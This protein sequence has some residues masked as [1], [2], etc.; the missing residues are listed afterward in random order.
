LRHYDPDLLLEKTAAARPHK[1]PQA[2]LSTTWPSTVVIMIVPAWR[3]ARWLQ[4]H[5]GQP[6]QSPTC[7]RPRI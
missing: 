3:E 2:C 1:G 5:T 4:D 6:S 7:I